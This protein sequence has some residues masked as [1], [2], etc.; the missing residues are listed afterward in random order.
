MQYLLKKY[1]LM[2]NLAFILFLSLFMASCSKENSDSF[3]PYTNNLVS[4]TAWAQQVPP[5]SEGFRLMESL[6]T[7]PIH[8]SLIGATGAVF[9]FPNHLQVTI[10][11]NGLSFLNGTVCTGNIRMEVVQL[12]RK[13]DMVRFS[14]PTTSYG[15]L[16]ESGG[17]FFIRATNNGQELIVSPSAI[18]KIKYR[19]PSPN[20]R[21]SIFYGVQNF[22]SPF[23]IGTNPGFT[24]TPATDSSFVNIFQQ[25]DSLGAIIRGYELFIKKLRWV[26]AGYFIDSTVPR[27][28]VNVILPRNFTN[29]NTNVFAVFN[30]EN[31]VVELNPEFSTRTFITVNIPTGKPITIVTL[32]KLGAD[33]H[34][35]T[36]QVTI[37][38][39][40]PVTV[41]PELKLKPQIEQFL[42]NL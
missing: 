40:Q 1:W 39:N 10:P 42:Q 38:A 33:L 3:F 16:L 6:M 15:K 18:I 7:P 13:G 32:S 34:L 31:I 4:D 2:K 23:P 27:T 5:N 17:S 21:M 19:Q 11:P 20:Q 25:Q 36:R 8:D 29:L 41:Q 14:R 28:R 26:S 37:T 22:N 35:G 12:R 9:N 30:N 24:W